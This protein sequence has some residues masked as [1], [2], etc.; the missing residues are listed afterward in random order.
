MKL[1]K[2]HL[3]NYLNYTN[4]HEYSSDKKQKKPP[5]RGCF[6]HL[7]SIFYL[8]NSSKKRCFFKISRY[9]LK[10]SVHKGNGLKT[11]STYLLFFNR[12]LNRRTAIVLTLS[13]M[14]T[15]TI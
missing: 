9:R 10:A 2:Q 13:A 14:Y 15:Y 5:N 3:I 11:F 7:S 6:L 8:P 4:I 1:L 12:E